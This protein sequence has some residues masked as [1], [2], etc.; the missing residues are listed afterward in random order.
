MTDPNFSLADRKSQNPVFDPVTVVVRVPSISQVRRNIQQLQSEMSTEYT[1]LLWGPD[2]EHDRY[3]SGHQPNDNHHAQF[4]ALIGVPPSNLSA[5]KKIQ[6]SKKSLYG[7]TLQQLSYQRRAYNL[8]ASISNI[9]LLSQ[10]VFGAAITGLGASS[11]SHVYITVFGAL[12]TVIAGLVA[13]LKSR[14]QPMRA[15]MYRD[16]LERVVDEIENSE[17]MWRGISGGVHGYEDIDTDEITV[18]SEIARLTRLYD[19]A[20][21]NNTMN[22]PDMYMAGAIDNSGPGLRKLGGGPVLVN[23]NVTLSATTPAVDQGQ[24]AGPPPASAAPAPVADPD[25]SPASAL[26][27]KDDAKKAEDKQGETKDSDINDD[28]GSTDKKD[29]GEDTKAE[30]KDKGKATSSTPPVSQVPQSSTTTLVPPPQIDPDASPATAAHLKKAKK[31][32]SPKKVEGDDED[33]AS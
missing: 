33:E 32:E 26:P 10:V 31:D 9:L 21:R 15:R 20:V 2:I 30:A 6:V 22:N 3:A 5:D 24:S 7:R 25:Q 13:Y 4:C 12:N 23:P 16:D 28:E 19:K 17:V 1:P 27:T 18:R 11:S 14:G 29:P 8:S